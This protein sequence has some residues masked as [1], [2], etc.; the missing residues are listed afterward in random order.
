MWRSGP[1]LGIGG[2]GR[3]RAADLARE[4]YAGSLRLLRGVGDARVHGDGSRRGAD[5]E[6]AR[7][8]A[9]ERHRVGRP[10]KVPAPARLGRYLIEE[11]AQ[12]AVVAD[13]EGRCPGREDIPAREQVVERG[14]IPASRSR[15]P[16]LLRSG[17]VRIRGHGYGYGRDAP[18][19]LDD[20]RKGAAA[21]HGHL[22]H[23]RRGVLVR[24]REGTRAEKGRLSHA[25]VPGGGQ[26]VKIRGPVPYDLLVVR[27]AAGTG[28]QEQG[29]R[30]SRGE[31]GMCAM[32][33][34]FL[35]HVHDAVALENGDPE[36][37]AHGPEIA[38]HGL[39]G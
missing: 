16:G 23:E 38:E 24:E 2:A 4:G 10:V 6:G 1:S 21:L 13:A 35:R 39:Q 18:Q 15:V 8:H 32:R 34:L 7:H 30:G 19:D 9:G 12:G 22:L 20:V 29:S 17:V 36:G 26:P 11:A 31:D 25:E 28:R 37:L 5:G 3:D 27:H 14:F 33:H